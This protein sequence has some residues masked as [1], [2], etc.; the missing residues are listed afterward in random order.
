MSVTRWVTFAA[1]FVVLGAAG[2]G[3]RVAARQDGTEPAKG[4]SREQL[5]QIRRV[6]HAPALDEL[7]RVID[8]YEV[9][10]R[11]SDLNFLYQKE[12][13]KALKEE[14]KALKEENKALKAKIQ[15]TEV[16]ATPHAPAATASQRMVNMMTDA[17][18]GLSPP[19]RRRTAP[20]TWF[21]VPTG[22]PETTI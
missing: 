2:G 18:R 3:V 21:P 10:V 22:S 20:A 19:V 9:R 13:N 12:E 8:K 11:T 4:V 16:D 14:N 1:V 6:S 17:A 5:P 15:Q 7:Q